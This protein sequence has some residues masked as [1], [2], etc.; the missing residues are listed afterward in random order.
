MEPAIKTGNFVLAYQQRQ[1][2]SKEVIQRAAAAGVAILYWYMHFFL[3]GGSGVGDWGEISIPHFCYQICFM[4]RAFQPSPEQT[5]LQSYEM[6]AYLFVS[7]QAAAVFDSLIDRA[8]ITLLSDEKDSLGKYV[9]HYVRVFAN[10]GNLAHLLHDESLIVLRIMLK[11]FTSDLSPI[12]LESARK[13]GV[14]NVVIDALH[15][16]KRSPQIVDIA[17]QVGNLLDPE[18]E[19]FKSACAVGRGASA[20]GSGSGGGGGGA[21]ASGSEGGGA[22]ASGGG[23]GGASASGGGGASVPLLTIAEEESGTE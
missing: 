18:N 3:N 17:I 2:A 19:G 13:K 10:F 1:S 8:I 4:M 11:L 22:S 12:A 15:I 14:I 6:D 23:G 5:V 9:D 16:H 7:A 20:S 21:S